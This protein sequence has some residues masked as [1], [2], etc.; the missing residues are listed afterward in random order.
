MQAAPERVAAAVLQQPIGLDHGNRS[1][2]EEMFDGWARELAELQPEVTPESWAAFRHNMYGGDFVFSVTRD[3]VRGCALSMLVL[4][5]NDAYHPSET[6]REIAELAPDAELIE[7]W[8][9][10]AVIEA[11]I[12]RVIGFLLRR[13]P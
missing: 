8:K 6:S 4:M 7:L 2:F 12:A 11:T 1:L 3:F 9:E 10:P 13:V 5:G